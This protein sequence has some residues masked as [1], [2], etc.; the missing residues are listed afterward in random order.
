MSGAKKLP[1]SQVHVQA[2]LQV[3]QQAKEMI[4]SLH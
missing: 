1:N 2:L 4:Y 3:E